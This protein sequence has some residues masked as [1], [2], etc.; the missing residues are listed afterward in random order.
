MHARRIRPGEGAVLRSIRLRALEGAPDAF[1][2]TYAQA[3]TYTDEAWEQRAAECA[4]SHA[5]SLFFAEVHGAVVGMA[6]GDFEADDPMPSL[7]SMWVE[8]HARGFGGGQVLVEAV[9]AW[10]LEQGASRLQLWVTET[11]SSAIALYRRMG[12]IDTGQTQVLPSNHSLM[13]RQMVR[14]L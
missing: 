6:G 14:N 11:N 13:E 7:I 1:G 4:A 3:L 2:T 9:A 8:P 10:A 5:T 12:F